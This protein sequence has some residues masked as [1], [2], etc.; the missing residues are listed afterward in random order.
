MTANSTTPETAERADLLLRMAQALADPDTSS[1]D[2]AALK[3]RGRAAAAGASLRAA[4]L[5]SRA[6]DPA[7]PQKDVTVARSEAD[8]AA[9]D[10]ERLNAAADA[11][12]DRWLKRRADEA[13]DDRQASFDAVKAERDLLVEKIKTR[14]PQ[15]ARE[16]ADLC[17]ELIAISMKVQAANDHRR[18]PPGAEP[19]R[20]ADGVARGF[21]D[22]LYPSRLIDISAIQM[23]Q[24][25]I[26]DPDDPRK[27]L[28]PSG[29]RMWLK[30]DREVPP[31]VQLVV[32]RYLREQ[33]LEQE[34]NGGHN[35][36]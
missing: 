4:D 10:V 31:P 21:N 29:L 1:S 3:E 7:L 32:D 25:V 5:R 23:I 34:S 28:W 30:E 19:L 16:M 8:A 15:L 9:F 22:P 17:K 26:P 35:G 24:A 12:S 2:L 33:R 36:A 11:I 13:A 14:Y 20:G 18:I 6:L 27:L